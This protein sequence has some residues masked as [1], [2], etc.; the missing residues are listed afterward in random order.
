[1]KKSLALLSLS[2]LTLTACFNQEAAVYEYTTDP[3]PEAVQAWAN[4]ELEYDFL[5]FGAIKK[6]DG[7]EYFISTDTFAGGNSIPTT[8][9]RYQDSRLMTIGEFDMSYQNIEG[10]DDWVMPVTH[11]LGYG[12]DKKGK[13]YYIALIQD[14]SDSPGPC[15]QPYLLGGENG[16]GIRS[17]VKLYQDG[18]S[19]PR[20]ENLEL[21]E[22]VLADAQAKQEAC[23][24]N[25]NQ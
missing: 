4:L 11:L 16:A 21:P 23:Q 13:D 7:R 14:F 6:E 10:L 25:L 15:A 5:E 24:A 8:L 19:E 20:F 2:A 1:M 22:E 3:S 12:T 18:Y 17:I 9:Y